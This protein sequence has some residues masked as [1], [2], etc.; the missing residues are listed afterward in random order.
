MLM[1]MRVSR[2]GHDRLVE[3]EEEPVD[4]DSRYGNIQ[5]DRQRPTRDGFVF[6]ESA[7][8][9]EIQSDDDERHN[10]GGKNRVTDEQSEV[11]GANRPV[12]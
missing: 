4:D 3:D 11:S 2:Q 9:G 1:S 8:Q 12:S 6:S 5:P 7:A 10:H